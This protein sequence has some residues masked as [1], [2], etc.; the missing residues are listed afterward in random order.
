MLNF[1][2]IY[3]YF[4]RRLPWGNFAHRI[5][6]FSRSIDFWWGVV[7]YKC[8]WYHI[9]CGKTP[10]QLVNK[11]LLSFTKWSEASEASRSEMVEISRSLQLCMSFPPHIGKKFFFLPPSGTGVIRKCLSVCASVCLS[12]PAKKR[13]NFWTGR[14]IGSKFSAA[15]THQESNFWAGN[16]DP[17]P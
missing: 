4:T 6:V 1:Y 14:R 15:P 9:L 13:N 3:L 11:A 5:Y 17:E 8:Q 7:L 2:R 10:V 16:L 12:V